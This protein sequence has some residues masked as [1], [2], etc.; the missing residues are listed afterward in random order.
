MEEVVYHGSSTSGLKIIY[1]HESTHGNYV[2]AT[3]DII[4]AT[5]FCKRCGDDVTYALYK[6]EDGK[7]NLVE[8]LPGAFDKM[9][10]NSASIY[11]VQGETFKN[12][13][14]NFNEI[15]SVSPVRVLAEEFI[16]NMVTEI[17]R[18]N[19]HGDIHLYRYP[20]KPKDFDPE[21]HL[22]NQR[23]GTYLKLHDAEKFKNGVYRLAGYHPELIDRI[24][25]EIKD[26][27]L[28]IKPLDYKG[29]L[30]YYDYQLGAYMHDSTHERYIDSLLYM[31]MT[32]Y[33]DLKDKIME[34]ASKHGYE[35]KSP[36][37]EN[38]KQV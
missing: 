25:K 37:K 35:Y 9:F 33:P 15:M 18:L 28:D 2:Y 14:T 23:F 17:N 7:Y 24:N 10:N 34:L 3:T 13:R 27:E 5:L 11:T 32:Y 29:L 19:E 8:L 1:P 21:E 38:I 6:A 30:D 12:Y 26:H 31:G 16:P 4:V 20:D 36:I 22:I